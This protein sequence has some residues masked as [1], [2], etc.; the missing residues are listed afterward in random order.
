M[1]EFCVGVACTLYE[2]ILEKI[3]TTSCAELLKCDVQFSFGNFLVKL[4]DY[5]NANNV[6]KEALKYSEENNVSVVNI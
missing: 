1:T 2:I 4:E 5:E 6:L 3:N